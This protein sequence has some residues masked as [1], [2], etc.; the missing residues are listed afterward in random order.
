MTTVA[1]VSPIALS[2][3]LIRHRWSALGTSCE[4]QFACKEVSQ[5]QAF[6]QAA[7]AWVT[8]FECKYS[9]FRD[10]SEVSRINRAAGREWVAITPEMEEM[11]NL[12]GTLHQ[13]T[14]GI[15]DVTALPLL[16]LWNF[17]AEPP[18][19]PDAQEI[20]AAR[21]LVGWAKVQRKPGRV[22]LPLCGMALDF[23]GWGKEFAV[24]AVAAI[25][26][27]H[28]VTQL[29]V[30]FGHDIRALGTPPARPAW[31][32]GLEDPTWPG[33]YRGSIGV[34]NR[35]VASSGDYLRG[36]TIGERRYGH[37]IDPRTGWPVANGT[38]QVTVVAPTCL[39]AG[40]LS[41]AAFILGPEQGLRLIQDTFGAEGLIVT[42]RAR[43][44]SRGFFQYV[45]QS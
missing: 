42:Q 23:G 12:C 5:G 44:Q 17:R 16:R 36:F 27:A 24:D 45:V 21:A 35:G 2:T 34:Q 18:R 10:D 20:E 43:H 9:R 28:G 14:Q 30:D 40:I 11:L 38:V 33:Q 15:L 41:T 31:H 37:I 39:Q 3:N 4:L 22:F 25:G 29:L 26:H 8:D 6:I 13:M 7:V 19:V 1:F 32:I